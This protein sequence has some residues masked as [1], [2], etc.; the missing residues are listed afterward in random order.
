MIWM[1]EKH[2]LFF[3]TT[4]RETYCNNRI[5]KILGYL[6]HYKT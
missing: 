3:T 2:L 1:G 5:G 4:K 6:S